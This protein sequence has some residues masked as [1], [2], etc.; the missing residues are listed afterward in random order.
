LLEAAWLGFALVFVAELGD[1]SQLLVV[2]LA[3][4]LPRG[5]VLAGV[6]TAAAVMQLASVGVGA[7]LADRLPE[8]PLQVGAA[9]LFLAFAVWTLLTGPEDGAA[10]RARTAGRSAYLVAGSAF[11]LAELGDKTMLATIA[12]ASRA[13]RVG[14]WVGTTA[15]MVASSTLAV[16]VGGVLAR[17]IPERVVRYAA[18]AAF[19]VVGVALLLGAG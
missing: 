16:L 4:R 2:S 12:L 17:R 11:L 18:A 9:V 13:D 7:L 10:D 19:A 8:R 6:A 14:V 1:K 15:A 3:S 5:Q